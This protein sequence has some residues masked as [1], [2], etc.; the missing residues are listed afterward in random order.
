MSDKKKKNQVRE[1]R[2]FALAVVIVL[3]C[4]P[5]FFALIVLWLNLHTVTFEQNGLLFAMMLAADAIGVYL[6]A[7]FW[8][9]AGYLEAD[10]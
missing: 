1:Y 10:D 2:L 4:I 9:N 7:F 3:I 5:T 8:A 6:L